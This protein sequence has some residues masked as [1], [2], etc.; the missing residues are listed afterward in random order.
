MIADADR[1]RLLEAMASLGPDDAS[2]FLMPR[3]AKRL[4]D[5]ATVVVIGARG[6]GKSALTRFVI[7][8]SVPP[9]G[10]AY[11]ML[12]DQGGGVRIVCFDAFSRHGTSHPDATVLDDF[13][14]RAD[15]EKL[16]GFWLNWLVVRFLRFGVDN[17]GFDTSPEFDASVALGQRDPAKAFLLDA[18]ERAAMVSALDR[19]HEKLA[20]DAKVSPSGVA[21]TAVYDDLDLIGTFDPTLRARFVRAL[22]ALWSS[23]STRYTHLRAKIFIPPDLL[24]LRRFDTVDVS[25]LMA[26]AERLEWSPASLYRLVL[27]HLGQRGPE[28]RAWLE[29]FGVTFEDLGDGLGWMPAE[30]SVDVQH[31][32]LTVTLRAIVSVN[33]TTSLVEQW[34]WNRLR[35]GQNRVAPRSMLSFFRQAARLAQER[36]GRAPGDRLLAVDDAVDAIG[37]VGTD[38]VAEIRAVY[39]WVDRL[40]ALRG[41]GMPKPRPEIEALLATDPRD[42]P[43][44]T[45]PR[46][47]PTVTRELIRM[48]LLRELKVDDLLDLPDV[49]VEHFGVRRGEERLP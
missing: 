43:K 44:P 24:D 13:V 30:P 26:H 11:R 41:K 25:K 2:T 33:G 8:A 4:L 31:R 6:S 45:D 46:D 38:R 18:K 19:L 3:A 7:G 12:K 35:D 22:L 9:L 28:V 17:L 14:G 34:I 15:D 42:M 23:F 49:F 27:R 36:P 21:F 20:I 40:E 32:W 1:A 47:G 39:E 10:A 5:P 37:V 16:R 48:G 29:T